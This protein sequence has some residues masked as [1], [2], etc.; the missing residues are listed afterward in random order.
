MFEQLQSQTTVSEMV[1]CLD[2]LP[3]GLGETYDRVLERIDK[4]PKSQRLLAHKVFFWIRTV[5]RPVSIAELCILLAIRPGERN[6]DET[7]YVRDAEST[8]LSVCSPLLQVRQPGNLVFPVHFTVSQY[9]EKYLEEHQIFQQVATCYDA[10]DLKSGNSLAAAV[11]LT[12][13]S[14]PAVAELHSPRTIVEAFKLGNVANQKFSL[15]SYASNYWFVHLRQVHVLE[16]LLE[17]VVKRFL[18]EES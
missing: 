15:L 13:L 3:D 5:Q 9:L 7:R 1:Q 16:S 8:I 2:E 14:L 12:Y 18:T 6:L 10:N 4:H 11:C 17:D